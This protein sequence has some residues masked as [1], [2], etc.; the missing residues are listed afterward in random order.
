VGASGGVASGDDGGG[1]RAV[2]V[3]DELSVEWSGESG[4]DS[5]QQR[6]RVGARLPSEQPQ[7]IQLNRSI[8]VRPTAGSSS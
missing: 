1:L 8:G 5:R 3:S 2:A 6:T 4:E 7:C